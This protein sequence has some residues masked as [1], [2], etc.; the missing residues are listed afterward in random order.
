MLS[1]G[2][3]TN[4]PTAPQHQNKLNPYFIGQ[5]KTIIY[6]N[7]LNFLPPDAQNLPAPPS[8]SSPSFL[9][10]TVGWPGRQALCQ[11]PSQESMS[12]IIQSLWQLLLSIPFHWHEHIQPLSSKN[13]ERKQQSIH[14]LILFYT[15]I[16]FVSLFLE[17]G[18]PEKVA[19]LTSASS[20]SVPHSPTVIWSSLRL[21][22]L[23]LTRS[24]TSS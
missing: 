19:A 18:L 7:A 5:I 1:H 3:P 12:P 8:V 16:P 4:S 17:V 15:H 14:S 21:R 9:L 23:L 24:S 6:G 20:P 10:V 2:P 22:E 11:C 13:Q